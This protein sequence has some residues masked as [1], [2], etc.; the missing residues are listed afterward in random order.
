MFINICKT[1]SFIVY[2]D[3]FIDHV[4]HLYDPGN[5]TSSEHVN[6]YDGK[7]VPTG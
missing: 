3:N 1:I 7:H 2:F 5:L 6:C 4:C